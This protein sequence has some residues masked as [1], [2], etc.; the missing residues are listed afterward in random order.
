MRTS[1]KFVLAVP[2]PAEMPLIGEF[3]A[4]PELVTDPVALALVE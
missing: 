4:T 2:E 3:A 1:V